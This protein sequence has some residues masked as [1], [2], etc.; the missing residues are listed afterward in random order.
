MINEFEKKELPKKS[1]SFQLKKDFDE[2]QY[3]FEHPEL[4]LRGS[5]YGGLQHVRETYTADLLKISLFVSRSIEINKTEAKK[6]HH[7]LNRL[8]KLYK[9]R[10]AYNE[11]YKGI[12]FIKQA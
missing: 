5:Y 6:V 10:R 12:K 9:V 1:L 11:L 2:I 8:A 7:G 3:Y 4:I